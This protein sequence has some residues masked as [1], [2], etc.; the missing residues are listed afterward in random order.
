M[1]G[2]LRA[3]RTIPFTLVLL[4]ALL[5]TTIALQQ[6]SSDDALVR[7]ASTNVH[8]LTHRPI[9]S[10]VASAVVLTDDQWPLTLLLLAAGLG[11]LERRVGTLRALGIFASGHVIATVLT[12]AAVGLQ[13]HLGNLPNSAAW[14]LD[15]GISYGQWALIGAALALLPGRR[16][17]RWL[18]TAGLALVVAVPLLRDFD[19]TAGGHAVAFLVGVAWWRWLPTATASARRPDVAYRTWPIARRASTRRRAAPRLATPSKAVAP[20]S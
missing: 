4:A 2:A 9:V 3:A 7:W 10:L 18:A 14:Q 16:G 1:T 12:E 15:A 8:N 5:G 6:V 20:G 13:L 11:L 17:W 19:M